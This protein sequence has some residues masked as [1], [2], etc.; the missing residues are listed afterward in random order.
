MKIFTT[1]GM[2]EES[3]LDYS[4]LI[5]DVPCGRCETKTW[6]KDGVVVKQSVNIIISEGVSTEGSAQL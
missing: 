4:E 2:V 6:K 1:L 3:E 5:E